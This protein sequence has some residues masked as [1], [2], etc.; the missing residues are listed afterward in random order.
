[1]AFVQA[2]PFT[3]RDFLQA[4]LPGLIGASLFAPYTKAQSTEE[5]LIGVGLFSYVIYTPISEL[6]ARSFGLILSTKMKKLNANREWHARNWNYDRLFYHASNEDREYLYLTGAYVE[7]Y[8]ITAFY[9]L[10][11]IAVQIVHLAPALRLLSPF[12]PMI[13]DLS[14]EERA[15]RFVGPQTPILGG[16]NI[17]TVAA[18]T[19]SFVILWFLLADFLNEYRL[20]FEH[21]YV[22]MARRYHAEKGDV[23]RSIWG[24]V[25]CDEEGNKPLQG[26][27]IELK[28]KAGQTIRK[29]TTNS[30]GRFQFADLFQYT[31]TSQSLVKTQFGTQVDIPIDEKWTPPVRIVEKAP[32]A[33]LASVSK[34]ASA[35]ASEAGL[36]RRRAIAFAHSIYRDSVN[37]LARL[38]RWSKDRF[39]KRTWFRR[40]S[41]RGH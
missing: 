27:G 38:R 15:N 19:A 9:F 3:F 18:L 2:S 14:F 40:R 25:S 37:G 33:S 39:A 23:A 7:F 36:K 1:M 32:E 10:I 12:Y 30:E 21:Q 35:Q 22:E 13:Y 4:I 29:A 41:R 8:R 20:L 26:V 34:P 11:Y 28:D 24:V 5:L 31:R 6:A 17:P 16:W